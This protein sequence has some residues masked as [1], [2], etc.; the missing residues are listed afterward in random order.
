[1]LAAL[2]DIAVDAVQVLPFTCQPIFVPEPGPPKIPVALI[3]GAL[4]VVPLEISTPLFAL[5]R[6]LPPPEM[7]TRVMLP[8]F[9]VRPE[10]KT[11]LLAKVPTGDVPPAISKKL[12]VAFD[13]RGVV[14]LLM[15]TPELTPKVTEDPPEQWLKA[16]VGVVP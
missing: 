13:A 5:E 1:M 10:N 4:K 2:I 9:T 12:N 6:L 3:V 8:V 16:I 7:S 15:V 11:P 14:T